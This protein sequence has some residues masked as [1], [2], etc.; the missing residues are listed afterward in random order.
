MPA[1]KRQEQSTS[2]HPQ[3]NAKAGQ[4][5]PKQANAI[6]RTRATTNQRGARLVKRGVPGVTHPLEH[7]H[8]WS[9]PPNTVQNALLSSAIRLIVTDCCPLPEPYLRSSAATRG[10]THTETCKC[11]HGATLKRRL[12]VDGAPCAAVRSHN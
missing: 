11:M 5:N 6:R 12:G 7:G 1:S 4:G 2:R 3:G 10:Q 9:M 8:F